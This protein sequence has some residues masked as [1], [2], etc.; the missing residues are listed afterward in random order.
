MNK[1]WLA[2][3][4]AGMP[5]EIDADVFRSIPDLFEKVAIIS[6]LVIIFSVLS[7]VLIS[8]HASR[9]HDALQRAARNAANSAAVLVRQDGASWEK[10]LRDGPVNVDI[11]ALLPVHTAGKATVRMAEGRDRPTA[12]IHVRVESAQTNAENTREVE[13]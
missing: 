6:L 3:Y 1:I 11:T 2:H 7:S 5:A 12:L 13:L 4:P 10:Q 8:V 9:R